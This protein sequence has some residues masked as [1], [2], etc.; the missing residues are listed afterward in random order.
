ML[1]I[2]G[3][4]ITGTGPPRTV[5]GQIADHR[6]VLDGRNFWQHTGRLAA[7]RSPVGVCVIGTGETSASIV[8]ELLRVLKPGSFVEVVTPQGVLYSRGESFFE[9]QLYSNPLP[10]WPRLAESHRREFLKRTDR[11]VFSVHAEQAL[12]AAPGCVRTMAGRVTR[13]EVDDAEVLV[14]ISY[15]QERE[16]AAYDFVVVAIGFDPVWFEPLLS[17][18]ARM[19]I[20]YATGIEHDAAISAKVLERI[21]FDLGVEKL[22]PRLHLP[23]MA[24]LE[25]G[26]GFPNL[27]CLGLMADRILQ[28]YVNDGRYGYVQRREAVLRSK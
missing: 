20:R 7:L 22:Q 1:A 3:L 18:S 13:L 19:A 28:P 9:N 6:R 23:M 16:C 15:L 26:P 21:D 2:D 27:S 12:N 17:D 4:V 5:P 14:H 24:G 10:E 11:G 25:Q 8:V